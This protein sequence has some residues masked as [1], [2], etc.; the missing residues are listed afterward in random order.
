M[1]AMEEKLNELLE[2]AELDIFDYKKLIE[3]IKHKITFLKEA[4]FQKEAEWHKHGLESMTYIGRDYQNTVEDIRK[5]LND[6]LL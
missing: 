5:L 2:K 6:W 3:E 4:G 1:N